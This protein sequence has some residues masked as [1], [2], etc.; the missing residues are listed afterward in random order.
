[1]PEDQEMNNNQPAP[2]RP[3][4]HRLLH[5]I[6]EVLLSFL[7]GSGVFLGLVGFMCLDNYSCDGFGGIAFYL[8][9]FIVALL[10]WSGYLSLC[11]K[12]RDRVRARV[13]LDIATVVA[14][15]IL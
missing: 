11:R 2:E 15:V 4:L 5:T 8:A 13:K 10:I 14:S 12:L 1:M 7:F 3:L 6:G 9:S